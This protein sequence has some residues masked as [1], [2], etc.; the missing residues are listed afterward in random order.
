MTDEWEREHVYLHIYD[1][2]CIYIY[3]VCKYVDVYLHMH[4]FFYRS[5][6]CSERCWTITTEWDFNIPASSNFTDRSLPFP[7]CF[8]SGDLGG[9]LERQATSAPD[10][11][12]WSSSICRGFPAWAHATW[13][14]ELEP[15]QWFNDI[16]DHQTVIAFGEAVVWCYS[17]L[18]VL[19]CGSAHFTCHL[20]LIG[21]HIGVGNKQ[22]LWAWWLHSL[23]WWWDS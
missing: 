7:R 15:V 17:I 1:I 22:A 4:A 5:I 18:P 3:I 19:G 20:L 12:E 16:F 11:D 6:W 23:L 8:G 2:I 10:E 13:S 21:L 9:R 14:F